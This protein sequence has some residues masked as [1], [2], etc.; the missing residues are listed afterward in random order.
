MKF[1]SALTLAFIVLRLCHVIDWWWGWIVSPM[2]I[3][4]LLE[5]LIL[6]LKSAYSKNSLPAGE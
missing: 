2:V 6:A 5:T 1:S 3:A 4:F